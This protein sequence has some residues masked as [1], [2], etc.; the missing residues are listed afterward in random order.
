MKYEVIG[1]ETVSVEGGWTKNNWT[2]FPTTSFDGSSLVKQALLNDICKHR[3]RL[4][5]DAFPQPVLNNGTRVLL[6][7]ETI[8][9]LL[10]EAY[11]ISAPWQQG[12]IKELKRPTCEMYDRNELGEPIVFVVRLA[13]SL[14]R[15][16]KLKE[17]LFSDGNFEFI[18][19]QGHWNVTLNEGD[20]IRFVREHG[21]EMCDF[22][23]RVKFAKTLLVNQ[24]FTS[25]QEDGQNLVDK[26]RAL[27]DDMPCDT[28]YRY[29]KWS[30]KQIIDKYVATYQHFPSYA[31]SGNCENQILA[32]V[33][34]KLS[35][36]EARQLIANYGS[37]YEIVQNDDLAKLYA[38]QIGDGTKYIEAIYNE[39]NRIFDG[40]DDKT[41]EKAKNGVAFYTK[42]FKNLFVQGKYLS[43]KRA[44]N[45]LQHRTNTSRNE[46]DI[47]HDIISYLTNNGYI[48]RSLLGDLAYA[49]LSNP[50]QNPSEDCLKKE[51]L[52][53]LSVT[54]RM[55]WIEMHH[56][57]SNK[58]QNTHLDLRCALQTLQKE[59]AI[60]KVGVDTYTLYSTKL[61]GLKA[62]II[63]ILSD[64]KGRTSAD[65]GFEILGND[66]DAQ[67]WSRFVT[68]KLQKALDELV[69]DGMVFPVSKHLNVCDMLDELIS[70][71]MVYHDP[72]TDLYCMRALDDDRL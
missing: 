45:A 15:F 38:Q 59:K 35:D 28:N 33:F 69:S 21:G 2:V 6:N 22:Y 60:R 7:E 70:P 57:L 10:K 64:G 41:G 42:M 50:P 13:P 16:N 37:C 8:L 39:L 25:Y 36:E 4:D 5:C 44:E 30:V 51:I 24:L 9:G 27:C 11:G 55:S 32:V 17:E 63:K 62:K 72:H 61:G 52:S 66:I 26:V 53:L 67:K 31:M 65:L 19:Y 20:I 34:E 40:T 3:Y 12:C 54:N 18:P 47:F 68:G 56:I 48:K 71:C 14:K 23:V 58:Y 43:I 1:W 29:A 49:T 46:V